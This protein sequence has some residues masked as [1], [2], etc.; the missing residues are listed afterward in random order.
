MAG[1]ALVL[2]NNR[3]EEPTQEIKEDQ[4]FLVHDPD[5]LVVVGRIM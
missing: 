3:E 2:R 4:T 5:I 1:A